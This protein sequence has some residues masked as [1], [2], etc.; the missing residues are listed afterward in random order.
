MNDIRKNNEEEKILIEGKFKY[1]FGAVLALIGTLLIALLPMGIILGVVLPQIQKADDYM[2][3]IGPGIFG[4]IWFLIIFLGSFLRFLGIKKN[5]L[6]VTNKRIY[7]TYSIQLARKKFSYRLDEIENVEMQSTFGFHHLAVQF[8]QGKGPIMMG[9]SYNNGVATSGGFNVFRISFLANEKEIY[10]TLN[11]LLNNTKNVMDLETD[12]KLEGIKAENRKAD[13]LENLAKNAGAAV[14]A[15]KS[16]S[17]KNSASYIEEL[18]GLKKLLDEGIITKEEF[19][20]EKKEI[21]DNN[22]K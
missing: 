4:I 13:A 11:D 21:L 2:I 3:L 20:K 9:T 5:Q 14:V 7:G 16:S 15:S 12:I 22:H 17:K 1:S 10:D 18:E 19:D 6:F 8:S